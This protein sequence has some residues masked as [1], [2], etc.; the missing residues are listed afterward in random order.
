MY[1]YIYI[2]MYVYHIMDIFIEYIFYKIIYTRHIFN[3]GYYRDTY[4]A[5]YT[6]YFV[7]LTVMYDVSILTYIKTVCIIN[8]ILFNRNE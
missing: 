7:R 5:H 8:S 3:V 6:L 1:I 2:Y 4:I